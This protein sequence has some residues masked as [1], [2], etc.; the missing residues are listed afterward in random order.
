M[1]YPIKKRLTYFSLLTYA[2]FSLTS[3]AL[4]NIAEALFV[5]CLLFDLLT[6]KGNPRGSHWST[7]SAETSKYLKRYVLTS[8]LLILAC[9]FS[10]FTTRFF[11]LLYGETPI[12]VH[13]IKD[14]AKMGYFLLPLLYAIAWRRLTFSERNQVIQTWILTFGLFSLFGLFQFFTGWIRPSPIPGFPGYYH[15]VLLLGHH[16]SVAN[17]WI[18]PFFATLHLFSV[19]EVKPHVKNTLSRPVLALFL[20]AGFFTLVLTF[21]RTLWI[22]L[23]IGLSAWIW[24]RFPKKMALAWIGSEIL[25]GLCCLQLPMIQFRLHHAIGISDRIQLWQANLEF[26]KN[27]LFFGIGLGK[28]LITSSAYFQSHAQNGQG[29]FFVGHAHNVYLEILSGIG[30]FGF[31]AWLIWVCNVLNMARDALKRD[32]LNFIATGMICA[33][34]VFLINGVTQVNFWEGKVLHQI[35]WMIGILL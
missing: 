5:C 12:E 22:A 29:V 10:L 13:W 31:I 30:I 20:I 6:Q 7:L 33:W 18:F 26:F 16:L 1:Q 14:L 4:M 9:I 25:F 28:N 27:R 17:I 24:I 32:R 15:T 3:M 2:V 11:P 35:M 34:I 23:P 21:S 8:A 19:M